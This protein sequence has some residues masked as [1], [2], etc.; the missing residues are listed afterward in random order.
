MPACN[1]REA[2][3]RKAYVP[4]LG[5][6]TCCILWEGILGGHTWEGILGGHT[7]C[8]LWEGILGG[9]TWEGILGGHT[10]CILWEEHHA[11]NKSIIGKCRDSIL[12][13]CHLS[14]RTCLDLIISIQTTAM[15]CL[16][17]T[18]DASRANNLM[19]PC[20]LSSAA[21]LLNVFLP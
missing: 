3:A 1:Q 17:W 19:E 6:H 21:F 11:I 8:I 4:I 15:D 12:L 20:C 5:G 18:L 7:C 10:C 16:P 2:A 14:S 9:H 13:D